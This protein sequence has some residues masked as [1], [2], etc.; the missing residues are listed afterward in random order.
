VQQ[1]SNKSIEMSLRTSALEYLGIVAARLR[2]DAVSSQLSQ[3]IIDDIVTK[4]NHESDK[5]DE[6]EGKRSTR[7]GRK[8]PEVC[9]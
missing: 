2:K 5:E 9:Y 7:S 8:S 4:V 1:F 6:E 3:E